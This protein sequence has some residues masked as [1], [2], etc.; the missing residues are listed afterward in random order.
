MS[1]LALALP[2]TVVPDPFFF[3]EFY[4]FRVALL[5]FFVVGLYRLVKHEVM[6]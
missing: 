3:V 4:A 1:F 6:K 2:T 5:I